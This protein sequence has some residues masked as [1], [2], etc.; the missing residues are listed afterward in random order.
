[1]SKSLGNGVDPMD[2]IDKYGC[3]ALRYFL[4]TNSAPGMDLRYDE[5]K[6]KSSWNFIN[7]LWNAS[8]FVLMNIDDLKERTIL[9][10]ELTIY[11][12][13]I[14]TKKNELIKSTIKNMDKYDFHNVGAELYKFI[15]E[16][17]CDWYIEL[18]KTNMT[19]TTKTI[20]LDTLTDILKLLHPFMPY[21]TEEIYGMLPIKNAESIMIDTYPKYNKKD[22]Y[23]EESEQL[24]KVLEDIVAIRNLKATN[25]ITK[26]ALVNFECSNEKLIPIFASQLK[27]TEENLT[28]DDPDNM[29]SCNYKSQNI[30][31][32]YFF[33]QET[34]DEKTLDEEIKKLTQSI[35]RRKKLLSNENYVNKAPK[36][37]VEADRKKL[38]E[39]EEKLANLTK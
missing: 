37:V 34:K 25:K 4:T 7:K 38:R 12:K 24:E 13:W 6:V 14:L 3:D 18:T 17:F 29:I 2:V 27:I 5:E 31:I 21:V 11:D 22:I 8:R 32:T 9:E 28:S 23:K 36:N 39:E 15:W 10:E 30:S 20:L 26:N 33:E 35:E 19:K 16:D 1:M